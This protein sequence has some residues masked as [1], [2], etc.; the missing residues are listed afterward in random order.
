MVADNLQDGLAA[1][2][3]QALKPD[4][5]VVDVEVGDHSVDDGRQVYANPGKT[6]VLI[7]WVQ[8]DS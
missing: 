2:E 3:C 8:E 7:S 6:R 4:D 1:P 5:G